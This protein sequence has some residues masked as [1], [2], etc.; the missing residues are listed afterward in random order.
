MN[1]FIYLKS[2][3]GERQLLIPLGN[4]CIFDGLI[5]KSVIDLTDEIW[6]ETGIKLIVRNISIHEIVNA[7]KE[8]R[9]LEIFGSSCSSKI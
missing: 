9:L 5:R 2:R 7:Y 4:G 3:L 6:D 8:F 1:L